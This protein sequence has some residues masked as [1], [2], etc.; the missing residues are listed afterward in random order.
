M[1]T[2][3]LSVEGHISAAAKRDVPQKNQQ[4]N[5]SLAHTHVT[6]DLRVVT[7]EGDR[8]SFSAEARRAMLQANATG[9]ETQGA[10]EK[11]EGEVRERSMKFEI[12]GDLNKAERQDLKKLF[13][14][15]KSVG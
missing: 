15:I 12:E 2:N 5:V 6:S 10:P 3:A 13:R 4:T 14:A 11:V 7:A 8:V 1:L 9:G